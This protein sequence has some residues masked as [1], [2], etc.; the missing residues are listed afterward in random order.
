MTHYRPDGQGKPALPY[1]EHFG[2]EH[3]IVARLG[4]QAPHAAERG[5]QIDGPRFVRPGAWGHLLNQHYL[6]PL[7]DIQRQ[8][9]RQ[10]GSGGAAPFAPVDAAVPAATPRLYAYINGGAPE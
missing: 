9:R 1:L 2:N 5:I 6:Y 10:G 3:D 7:A 4:M 8:G